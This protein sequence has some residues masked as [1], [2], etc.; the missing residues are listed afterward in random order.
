[1]IPQF[2][3]RTHR[4]LLVVDGRIGFIG[5]AGIADWWNRDGVKGK[6]WRDMMVRVEG[7]AVSALQA[8]FAQ[9]WLRVSGEIL[10]E[11]EYFRFVDGSDQSSA[12]VIGSTPAAGSTQAR[13][14]YQLLISCA[15]ECI[16]ISTPY[17]LPDRSAQQAIIRA[18][19]E[20]MSK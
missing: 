9:N 10:T 15:R 19:R 8:V 1:L 7:P 20:G 2:N 18:V 4:E 13:I 5:G 17:F 6:R 14:L 12:L 3:N 16:Y 11:D